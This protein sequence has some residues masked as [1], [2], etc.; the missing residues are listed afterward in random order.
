MQV[1][2]IVPGQIVTVLGAG[3]PVVQDGCFLADPSADLLKLV[4]V[5]RHTGAGG[6][7]LGWVRGFGLQSGAMA[8]SVAHDSHNLIA[9]GV[10]DRDMHTAMTAVID[11]GGGMAFAR[12]GAVEALLPLPLA[13]LLSDWPA[14]KV[15]DRVRD[16]RAAAARAGCTLEA[17]FSTLSFLALPVIPEVRLTDLGLV[18]VMTQSFIG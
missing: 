9:A 4:V 17:P 14:T 11:A 12:D 3:R 13:G 2:E 5:E 16:L 8:S 1:I 15:C 18:D 7:S 10:S 6:F